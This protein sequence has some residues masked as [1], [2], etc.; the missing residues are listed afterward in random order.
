M[1]APANGGPADPAHTVTSAR[2]T[3]PAKRSATAP[4]SSPAG[5]RDGPSRR[6][7]RTRSQTDPD[8][9]QH[10]QHPFPIDSSQPPAASSLGGFPT[11]AEVTPRRSRTPQPASENL[12][13]SGQSPQVRDPRS[14]FRQGRH[15]GRKADLRRASNERPRCAGSCPPPRPRRARQLPPG[16]RCRRDQLTPHGHA[17]A[18]APMRCCR[19][20]SARHP[21]SADDGKRRSSRP[22]VPVAPPPQWPPSTSVLI[23]I[24]RA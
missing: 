11:R 19:P 16:G 7:P 24:I 5:P 2:C 18:R 9:G 4:V 8:P 23:G 1:P 15:G 22:P 17:F 6:A 12:H 21:K 20:P 14:Q 10:P 3:S 13:P